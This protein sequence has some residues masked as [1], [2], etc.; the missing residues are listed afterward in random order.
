VTVTDKLFLENIETPVGAMT[1]IADS[2][3]V[4]KLLEFRCREARWRPVAQKRFKASTI[5]ERPTG[6]LKTLQRYFDGDIT[7]LDTIAAD[8]GGSQFQRTVWA[9][10]RKVKPGATTSYGA[11]AHIIGKPKASR[12]V[13]HANGANPIALV[14]PCHRV[15]GT[16]GKLTGYGGGLEQKRY[17]LNH[18][19]RHAQRRLS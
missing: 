12:A 13:G 8:A 11:L 6:L 5:I 2:A 16:D 15:I 14:I 17:L 7:A 18:E 3:R 9:A 1:A 10:L 4:L 19:A